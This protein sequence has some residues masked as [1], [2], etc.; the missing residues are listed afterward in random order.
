MELLAKTLVNS[1]TPDIRSKSI[2]RSA[3]ALAAIVRLGT[4]L[5]YFCVLRAVAKTEAISQFEKA[6]DNLHPEKSTFLSLIALLKQDLNLT[7]SAFDYG[8]NSYSEIALCLRKEL[9][10]VMKTSQYVLC[11]SVLSCS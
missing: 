2:N 9:I 6:L 3:A 7:P 1:L 11:L 4:R 10:E 5:L 8:C